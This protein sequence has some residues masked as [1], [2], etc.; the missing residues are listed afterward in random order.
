MKWVLRI[1]NLYPYDGGRV[2]YSEGET[3]HFRRLMALAGVVIGIIGLFMKSLITDGESE[4][5]TLAQ[6]AHDGGSHFPKGIP[7]IWG[8]LAAWAQVLLVIFIILIVFLC[9]RPD[10]AKGFNQMDSMII[11]VIGVALLA[12][13]VYKFVDAGDAANSLAAGFA[14]M[15]SQ[16]APTSAHDVSRGVGFFVLIL[17]TVLIAAAGALGLAGNSES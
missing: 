11:G 7:T 6:I 8:G 15:A 13:A 10:I 5:E 16:G 14:A 3:V 12:Y 2:N 1:A 4:M 17:G 9:L